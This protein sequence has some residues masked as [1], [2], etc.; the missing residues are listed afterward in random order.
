MC[1]ETVQIK[2]QKKKPAQTWEIFFVA[3][4]SELLLY[5]KSALLFCRKQMEAIKI[6]TEQDGLSQDGLS[7]WPVCRVTLS[8]SSHDTHDPVGEKCLATGTTLKAHYTVGPW[9]PELISKDNPGRGDMLSWN[10][11]SSWKQ[12]FWKLAPVFRDIS[13]W[14]VNISNSVIA[15]QTQMLK[16]SAAALTCQGVIS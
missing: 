3:P 7:H 13:D 14:L 5:S 11:I 15:S 2:L 6:R 1:R 12:Q 4:E 10:L 9:Q 8:Y 16:V